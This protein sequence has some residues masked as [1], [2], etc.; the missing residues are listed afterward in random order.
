MARVLALHFER[1]P[2]ERVSIVLSANER[3]YWLPIADSVLVSRRRR[4]D[5][6]EREA[7]RAG[8]SSFWSS[9]DAARDQRAQRIIALEAALHGYDFDLLLAPLIEQLRTG[10]P[11]FILSSGRPCV[12]PSGLSLDR[13]SVRRSLQAAFRAGK[14]GL[15]T[16]RALVS[17]PYWSEPGSVRL[18][19]HALAGA[20]PQ[21]SPGTLRFLIARPSRLARYFTDFLET[22]GT[23]TA[24]AELLSLQDLVPERTQAWWNDRIFN[25]LVGEARAGGA[26]VVTELTRQSLVDEL[27]SV[28]PTTNLVLILHQ[29]E[30]GLHCADGALPLGELIAALVARGAPAAASVDLAVCM[31]NQA[32]NLA[33][34]LQGAGT[35]VVMT[36]GSTAYFGA[37][38]AT[39][40]RALRLLRSGWSG[41][42]P[43]LHDQL[44]LDVQPELKAH[45]RGE[46]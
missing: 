13:F 28:T 38:A 41:S 6:I 46:T 4:L 8:R 40:I 45:R 3:Q 27:V 29:D 16:L 15:T 20:L 39:W 35:P 11:A 12:V 30:Q 34:I 9:G 43:A 33:E 32:G 36:R 37:A 42:L 31:A 19:E 5:A 22:G 21:V 25:T 24:L 23:I 26:K 44:W 14:I 2:D 18:V 1:D 10:G 17:V 7:K